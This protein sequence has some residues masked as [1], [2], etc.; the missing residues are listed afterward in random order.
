MLRTLPAIGSFQKILLGLCC[1]IIWIGPGVLHSL[2][3]D[4]PMWRGPRG[5]GLSHESEA[6]LNWSSTEN[7]AWRVE[8]P[9]SGRSSPVI[10]S[11]GVYL[12]TFTESDR[13]RRLLRYDRKTGHLDW[14]TVIHLGDVENQHK[15]NTSA[16]ATPV[17]DEKRVYC[18]FVDSERMIVAA[19]DHSG[20]VV[21]KTS[22][23]SYFS[24]HGF[25]ASPA[26]CEEGLI[27]NGHQDGSAFVVMLDP[28]SGEERWRYRP[29]TDLRSFSTPLV[30]ESHGKRQ[31]VLAGAKQT[32]ALD[33]G[34][35]NKIWSVDGPTEKVVCTPSFGLGHVFSF[36]G[37]P[38]TRAIAIALRSAGGPI[39]SEIV[40]TKERAMPYVPTPL[41]Y[42]EYLHVI[43]DM[44]IYQCIEPV[45]GKVLK[46]QRKGGNTY[47]S[48]IG[49]ANRVYMFDD[50]GLC[51]VIE[52][53][54]EFRV[55]ARNPL[56][57]L[58]QT[59][60]AIS[61]GQLFIRGERH[62]WCIGTE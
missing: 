62:L 51:T 24:K 8:V 55:L 46:T 32:L 49:V 36:G 2:A 9:G 47:S 61:D 14:D 6:P 19:V 54:G 56:D 27:I 11:N 17:C 16:S 52:N 20:E 48:P 40:W 39:Q 22:P 18:T 26:L 38:D 58:I 31:I 42:G 37:S 23:G 41:L 15:F 29:E 7:I 59:T 28:K 4:W 53:N 21:W 33:P 5:D 13:A 1:N 30:I 34:S 3:E 10:Q 57:E 43:D 44:G 60:P 35:G 25:A 45:S 50:T 12:T